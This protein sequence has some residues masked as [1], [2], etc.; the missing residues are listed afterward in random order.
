VRSARDCRPDDRHCRRRS[1]GRVLRGV[2]TPPASG[3]RRRDSLMTATVRRPRGSIDSR[4]P[5][6]AVPAARR[7]DGRLGRCP[8]PP[9]TR[10][11]IA[12]G[13]WSS[14]PDSASAPDVALRPQ[15]S[16]LCQYRHRPVPASRFAHRRNAREPGRCAPTTACGSGV[17]RR[18]SA[19]TTS[20]RR[21]TRSTIHA[22]I[23]RT[24]N[25][26]VP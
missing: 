23:G 21:Y 20:A 24:V 25:G 18:S 2:I 10:R 5:G 8:D 12:R 15:P 19:A 26:L 22:D 11:S 9:L 3:A 6:S 4:D 7:Y 14:L 1:R 16:T 17:M 13:L